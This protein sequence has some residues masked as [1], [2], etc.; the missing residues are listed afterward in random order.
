MPRTHKFFRQIDWLKCS[1]YTTGIA[2]SA[3]LTYA[4]QQ[5]LTREAMAAML[6]RLEAPKGFT[7]PKTSPFADVRPSDKFYREIAW[8]HATGLSTG[9]KNP[10]GGKPSYQPKAK[11]SREAMAAFIYRLEAPKGFTAPAVSPVADLKRGDRFY[12]EVSWLVTEGLSTGIKVGSGKPEFR[13][14]AALTR[15]AMAAFLYRLATDYR[16]R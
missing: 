15:E 9:V 4:P 13:S 1:G 14:K 8:M 12:T 5:A 7:A 3:G 6:Y 11:L 2:T 16:E 10:A